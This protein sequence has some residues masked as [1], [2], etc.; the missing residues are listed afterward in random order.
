MF[1]QFLGFRLG[2]LAVYLAWSRNPAPSSIRIHCL[3]ECVLHVFLCKRSFANGSIVG[4]RLH[5][6]LDPTPGRELLPRLR[7][8]RSRPLVGSCGDAEA[9]KS[10]CPLWKRQQ[11]LCRDEVGYPLRI[12]SVALEI[13]SSLV[14]YKKANFFLLKPCLLRTLRDRRDAVPEVPRLEGK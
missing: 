8:V 9:G 7:P 1:D 14:L 4:R 11:S 12:H 3:L 2:C 6:L 10:V 13:A 5:E